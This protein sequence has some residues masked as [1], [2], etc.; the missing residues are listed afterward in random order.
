MANVSRLDR[1]AASVATSGPPLTEAWAGTMSA[2]LGIEVER[3]TEFSRKMASHGIAIEPS[4]FF[5]DPFY[6]Y[7]RL[8]LADATDDALLKLLTVEM[9]ERYQ[10]LERR[11]RGV[12]AFSRPH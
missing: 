3:L 9:F 12:L 1:S 10:A 6:A 7:K 5:F 11:R 8:A 4:R 2:S